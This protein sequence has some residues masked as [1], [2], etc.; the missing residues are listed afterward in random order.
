[1]HHFTVFAMR[2]KKATTT[3]I[4]TGVSKA[5]TYADANAE[6]R[7]VLAASRK[8]KDGQ[9]VRVVY[10]T[11]KTRKET[12]DAWTIAVRKEAKQSSAA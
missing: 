9:K 6:V 11:D 10:F 12:A 5:K 7:E 3:A 4:T 8:T 1:M 2:G